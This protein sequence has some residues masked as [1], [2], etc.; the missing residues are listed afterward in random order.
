MRGGVLEGLRG[1]L[2]ECVGTPLF[3]RET[4][5]RDRFRD[6]KLFKAGEVEG[7]SV[8]AFLIGREGYY[9]TKVGYKGRVITL[10]VLLKDLDILRVL[11]RRVYGGITLLPWEGLVSLGSLGF[12]P[13]IDRDFL[14]RYRYWVG[15]RVLPFKGKVVL[16]I[17]TFKGYRLYEKLIIQPTKGYCQ[18]ILT[19][20]EVLGYKC[21]TQQETQGLTKDA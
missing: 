9:L 5:Y 8:A 19:Q 1:E 20:V 7:V 4:R 10:Q 18:E 12:I 2:Q 13:A 15:G 17:G 14:V 3:S 16:A 21:L 11:E 6:Y